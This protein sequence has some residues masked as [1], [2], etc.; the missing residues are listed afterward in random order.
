[1]AKG[2]NSRK[3]SKDDTQYIKTRLLRGVCQSALGRKFG[4]SRQ[5]ISQIKKL[6][7][8]GKKVMLFSGLEKSD[9]AFKGF[10]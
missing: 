10:V 3:L 5:R 4:V 7:K 1:M 9:E 8:S 2:D 6:C